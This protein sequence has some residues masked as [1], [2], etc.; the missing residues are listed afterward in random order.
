MKRRGER[1][2]KFAAVVCSALLTGAVV[3]FFVPSVLGFVSLLPF[4]LV[5]FSDAGTER[6]F[7]RGMALGII[8]FYVY[9]LFVWHWFL[10]MYPLDFTE[11]SRAGALAAVMAAW[12]GLPL[13]QAVVAS[14]G[15]PLFL[16]AARSPLV[17]REGRLRASAPA[18]FAAVYALFEWIQSLTWAGVPW[19]RLA[20]GQ[21]FSPGTVGTAS[22]LGPYFVT[23]V[24]V[25]VNG[26][27]ALA[28]LALIEDRR[29]VRRA[30]CL[31]SAAAAVFAL[32]LIY[33]EARIYIKERNMSAENELTVTAAALQGNVSS[34]DKWSDHGYDN[35]KNVY[36]ALTKEAAA[37]GAEIA[38]FPETAFPLAANAASG[39]GTRIIP[40]LSSLSSDTGL[41]LLATSFWYGDGEEYYN[42][43][44]PVSPEAGAGYDGMTVYYK[45]HLVPFGEFVPFESVIKVLIP[46]LAQ[47]GLFD[48]SITTG[49]A[50][51]LIDTE[52]GR[53]GAMVCFDSIYE[54]SSLDEVRAGAELLAVSTNDSWFDGSAAIMQHTA[55]AV[56]RAVECDRYVVRA[57]NTG[58]SCIISPTG[59]IISSTEPERT[60][61]A[62]GEVGIRNTRTVYSRVG[63]VFSALC[64]VSSSALA[65]SGFF[66]RRRE[67]RRAAINRAP[68]A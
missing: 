10:L 55:Q 12:L 22:L 57:A 17:V 25:A 41:T 35:L 63:N 1:I 11:I 3:S 64:A 36:S 50:P 52:Y 54:T 61:L 56:L 15:V 39:N 19:G 7:R 21:A 32:N 38:V 16:W 30:A 33:G 4:L 46:S 5:L 20:V 51:V 2:L 13:I 58:F 53:V 26:Y 43:V 62:V 49:G 28:V 48:G 40:D 45:R 27:A 31:A 59:K 34:K 8:Y 18:V 14:L 44:F 24:I 9:Y 6:P 37:R 68:D 67:K 60:G 29:N 47:L 23:F 42:A 66:A 65:A